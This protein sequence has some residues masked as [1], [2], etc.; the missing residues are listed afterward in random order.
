MTDRRGESD[1]TDAV[2]AELRA[3]REEFVNAEGIRAEREH[4]LM[5]LAA[6]EVV[7]AE[8]IRRHSRETQLRDEA[9]ALR[10]QLERAEKRLADVQLKRQQREAQ[11]E[12]RLE[13]AQRRLHELERSTS[14][15]VGRALVRIGKLGR[16]GNVRPAPR[17]AEGGDAISP[18][19][20]V[21]PPQPRMAD[22]R[23]E[24][25]SPRP[26]PA[27]DRDG[28]QA[29]VALVLALDLREQDIEV[30][31]DTLEALPDGH[32]PV[33]VTDV[34]RFDL[35]RARDLVFEYLPP[36]SDLAQAFATAADEVRRDRI[37]DLRRTHA[38]VGVHRITPSGSSFALEPVTD[39][40]DDR[41]TG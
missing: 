7:E 1:V 25:G 13:V 39:D 27:S 3:L 36:R 20:T 15:R 5:R 28:V 16:G 24:Q 34:D 10:T 11:L 18:T 33:L 40:T 26:G 17:S 8:L 2:V 38:P 19:P 32:R 6:S 22:D 21:P 23:T 4:L 9:I 12:R 31:L 30:A 29:P 35:Y 37:A 41:G 14:L